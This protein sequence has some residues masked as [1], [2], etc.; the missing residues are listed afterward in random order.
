MPD[1]SGI[2]IQNIFYML[3]YAFKVLRQQNYQDIAAES[4]AHVQDMLAAILARGIVQQVKQGLYRKYIGTEEQSRTLRG[5]INL[6]QTKMLQSRKIRQF[7]HDGNLVG[8]TYEEDQA[9][10]AEKFPRR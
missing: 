2:L 5:K 4:F 7:D 3:C 10:L 6:Y 1:A 8:S 9:Y